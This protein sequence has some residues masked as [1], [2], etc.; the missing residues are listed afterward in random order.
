MPRSG[1]VRDISYHGYDNKGNPV[2]KLPEYLL[3]LCRQL[4]QSEM[5]PEQVLWQ[6][7]RD[8]KLFG[9]KFRRQHVFGR[10][11]ADFYCHAAGL[12]VELDGG[13][14][15]EQRQAEYDIV[16]QQELEAAGVRV[17]R[18]DNAQVREGLSEVLR[19]I[20]VSCGTLTP[21]AGAGTPLP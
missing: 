10:Y 5:P 12:V 14:H 11:V 13:V 19:A 4:R 2:I 21:P 18:F 1:G 8:R 16:R 15:Q 9:L 7:L 17:L 3:E 20:A 6:C